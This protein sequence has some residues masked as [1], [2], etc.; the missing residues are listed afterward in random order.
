MYRYTFTTP[1]TQ[2][3]IKGQYSIEWSYDEDNTVTYIAYSLCNA[4]LDTL[5]FSSGLGVRQTL[6]RKTLHDLWTKGLFTTATSG[7]QFVGRPTF[8]R[9]LPASRLTF[10]REGKNLPFEVPF[11]KTTC[12]LRHWLI[13]M[14]ILPRLCANHL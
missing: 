9:G 2:H 10:C 5:S 3:N 11:E 4:G 1:S 13:G 12:L 7:H 14:I 6:R 8:G